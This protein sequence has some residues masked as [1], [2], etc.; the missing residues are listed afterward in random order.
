MP[1]KKMDILY[2]HNMNIIKTKICANS[3]IIF[4]IPRKNDIMV[5]SQNVQTF[6]AVI[7][8]STSIANN[9]LYNVFTTIITN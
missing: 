5:T 6:H 2:R 4:G 7:R 3:N 9:V 1:A 8:Q